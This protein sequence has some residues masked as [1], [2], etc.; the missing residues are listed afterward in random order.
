MTKVG[1]LIKIIKLLNSVPKSKQNGHVTVEE[2]P[3]LIFK[4]L[5]AKSSCFCCFHI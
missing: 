2:N 1:L 3:R 5:K 4:M